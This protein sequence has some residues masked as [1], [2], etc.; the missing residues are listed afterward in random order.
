MIGLGLYYSGATYKAVELIFS[1]VFPRFVVEANL[2]TMFPGWC[3]VSST[4]ELFVYVIDFD[5]QD[6]DVMKQWVVGV[7]E[8]F[9][10]LVSEE[11]DPVKYLSRKMNELD[12]VKF[13]PWK[14]DDELAASLEDAIVIAKAYANRLDPQDEALLR[15]TG[16]PFN[17]IK[18]SAIEMVA[19]GLHQL[20]SSYNILLP[21]EKTKEV[22]AA[23]KRILDMVGISEDMHLKG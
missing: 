13:A 20:V 21:H 4:G 5:V 1:S 8:D 11:D 9:L 18:Q 16:H 23:R 19:G 22:E 12:K 15:L 6:A 17:P 3:S 10:N 2:W 7:M 14:S